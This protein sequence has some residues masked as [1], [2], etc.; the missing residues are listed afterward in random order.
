[1]W[2]FGKSIADRVKDAIKEQ[3]RLAALDLNVAERGGVVSISGEV[4]HQ[5][6]INATRITAEGVNGVKSVDVSGMI[7][8]QDTTTQQASAQTSVSEDE[9]KEIEDR[10]RIA[11]D[12]HKAIKNNAE[13]KDDPIDV[14]QSGSSIVLRGVVDNDHELRL[15]EKLAN[16]VDGVTGVD[17]SGLRVHE[18][19]K[20]LAAEQNEETGDTVYTVKSGDT[21]GAIAQRYYGDAS[22][23]MKI[24]NYNNIDNPDL[25]QVGQKLKIPA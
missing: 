17:V 24:A 3:S 15:A 21:L 22:Q 10:S 19:A 16:D 1:M 20:E 23:Y 12:V 6:F 14:L 8:Q 25:I 18:G 11:K 2:P 7:A 5:G 9:I 4:P 13:L